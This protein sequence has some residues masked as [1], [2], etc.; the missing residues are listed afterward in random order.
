MKEG[1]VN[2][3]ATSRKL[4]A[5]DFFCC[6]GGVTCGFRQAG[7]QVLGGI[8]IDDSYKETYEKNNNGSKFIHADI[9]ELKFNE[10]E[11]QLGIKRDMD[12]LIFVGCS[13]C[14]YYT[15]LQTNKT[16]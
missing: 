8:D 10:L 7:I 5:V 14:Q 6:A 2:K 3:K 1:T 12:D 11:E 16:K 13:P 15:T 4:K 9:S